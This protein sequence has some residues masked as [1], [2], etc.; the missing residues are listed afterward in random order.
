MANPNEAQPKKYNLVYECQSK[1]QQLLW[2][3]VFDA[4]IASIE[5]MTEEE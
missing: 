5:S 3:A 2:K 4:A 1:E